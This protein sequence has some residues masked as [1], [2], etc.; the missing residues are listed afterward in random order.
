[1]V[2]FKKIKINS[3]P[4]KK[5][6][7]SSLFFLAPERRTKKLS[8][9]QDR[10]RWM[11]TKSA[12]AKWRTGPVKLWISGGSGKNLSPVGSYC[13]QAYSTR[14]KK[15]IGD[16]RK[17]LGFFLLEVKWMAFAGILFQ[18]VPFSTLSRQNPSSCIPWH[19]TMKSALQFSFFCPTPLFLT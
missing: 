19:S 14:V 8:W 11:K 7:T 4:Q 16:V 1:M 12:G 17:S 18:G 5:C 9:G 3:P 13:L 15:Q 2:Y 10:R 6:F